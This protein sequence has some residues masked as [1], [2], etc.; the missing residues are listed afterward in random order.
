[1]SYRDGEVLIYA[2]VI[3][4]AGFS[5]TNVSRGDKWAILNSGKSDHYAVIRKGEH[6][7]EWDSLREQVSIYR[8][9]IEVIQRINDTQEANYDACLEYADAVAARIDQYRKLA[10]TTGLLRDANLTGGSEA[11]GI[12]INTGDKPGW[13]MVDL[14]VDWQEAENVT[15]AE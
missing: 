15:F 9:I 6:R 2:Q 7:R 1:M 8:T 12:W 13:I 11:K 4:V 14:F 10:D 5:A 3:Q